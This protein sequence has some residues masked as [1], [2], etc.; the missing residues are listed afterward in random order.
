MKNYDIVIVGGGISGL[1]AACEIIT[2]HPCKILIL[3]KGQTYAERLFSH[4]K[5]HLEGLGGAGTIAGGKLCY[6]PASGK[7]W[8]KTSGIFENDFLNMLDKYML[9]NRPNLSVSAISK[10]EIISSTLYKKAYESELIIP[11]KMHSIINNLINMCIS[12]GVDI[13]TESKF[14]G[15]YDQQDNKVIQYINKFG[16]V[17]TVSADY[18]IFAGGRSSSIEVPMLLKN[19]KITEESPDLGIRIVFPCEKN[20]IFSQLGKDIKIKMHYKNMTIRTFCVCSHGDLVK[21]R[22]NNLDYYDGHFNENLS[23]SVNLGI[24]VRSPKLIGTQ[25]AVDFIKAYQNIS[26]EILSFDYFSK[27]YNALAV[28]DEHREIFEAIVFFI[29]KL[30]GTNNLDNSIKVFIPSVDHLNPVIETNS[31]FET[32]NHHLFVIGD[33]TGISRGFVQSMWSGYCA[34]RSI[35]KQIKTERIASVS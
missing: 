26:K 3:E 35:I 22:Y 12:N 10:S 11:S 20:E 25:A 34:A 7:I 33:A 6:P 17:E 14:I 1:S 9:T 27:N 16:T 5:N 28:C 15:Y 32:N 24:L 31:S 21:V 29:N 30:F 18:L 13:F 8:R 2:S 23:S 19:C 4:N